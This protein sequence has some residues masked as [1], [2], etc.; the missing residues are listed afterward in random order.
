MGHAGAIISGGKG[1]AED[2][3]AAMEA[4]GIRVSPSPARLGKTLVEVDEGLRHKTDIPSAGMQS[5]IHGERGA[6]PRVKGGEGRRSA[7][8]HMARS[9]R[10]TTNLRPHSFLYGGNAAY[11]EDLYARY[12][13]D[14]SSVDP[15]WQTFFGALKDD[16]KAVVQECQGCA[17]EEADWPLQANGE[18]VSALDGNWGRSRRRSTS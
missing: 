12:Q 7:D 9:I 14:P 5:G 3:I 10:P 8:Q 13:N 6:W 2:K 4:A 1:G 18:L 16:P 15:E 11:I 17:V